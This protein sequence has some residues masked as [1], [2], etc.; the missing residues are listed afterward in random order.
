MTLT[1][2]QHHED[3]DYRNSSAAKQ[4]AEVMNVD[5]EENSEVFDCNLNCE[6]D[7]L[8]D[9]IAKVRALIE[10]AQVLWGDEAHD[11]DLALANVLSSLD[12]AEDAD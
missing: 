12:R 7:A 11:V 6:Q 4:A 5:V 1:P 2:E 3:C 9:L 10:E 8:F